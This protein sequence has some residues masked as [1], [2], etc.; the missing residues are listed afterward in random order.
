[1]LGSNLSIR[2]S[3]VIKNR[4]LKSAMTEQLGDR[5]HNP[6]PELN[7][8][9][10]YWAKGGI[11]L[12]ISGNIMIRRDALGE[13]KNVVLDEASDLQAFKQWTQAAT[14]NNTHCWAQLNH[15]GKQIPRFLNSRPVAPSAIPL[16]EG[17][18][19]AFAKPRS[20]TTEDVHD[21][22]KNFATSA[23]LASQVG[24]NGVQIH[25]AHGYLVSQFLSKRHNH[26]EDEW[27]GS[28]E[29][30]MAFPLAILK[31][32]RAEVPESFPI[33][34]KLNSFDFMRDGTD[35]SEAMETLIAL[36]EAGI[37]LIEISGGTYENPVLM[38]GRKTKA[39]TVAREGYFLSF[40]E[41]ARAKVKCPLAVTGGF[42]SRPF[43]EQALNSGATDMIGL[44]RPL[45]LDPDYPN[46]LLQDP[47]YQARVPRPDTGLRW[48][49]KALALDVTYYERQLHRIA[50]N[51]VANPNLHPLMSGVETLLSTGW[52]AFKLRRGR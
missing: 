40:A 48:L 38:T 23:R 26:R 13:P 47:D 8:L 6:T 22:V 17:L 33:G 35:E 11:G 46:K 39:S 4:L 9:Y 2:P 43:M 7:E 21:I 1:M 42:R 50:K 20:L 30:R 52:N 5:L 44:A 16:G 32:M 31:A 27:G 36:D 15:P 18:E 34:I 28:L 29:K 10:R 37:D 3:V 41:Q 45:A 24:F 25:G 51:G 12:S 49:N 14:L 19:N